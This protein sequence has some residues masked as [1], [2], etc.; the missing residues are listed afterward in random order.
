MDH[1]TDVH[2]QMSVKWN[3]IEDLKNVSWDEVLQ[4]E[5]ILS[6]P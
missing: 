6:P 4:G 2:E 5:V 1:S 3:L